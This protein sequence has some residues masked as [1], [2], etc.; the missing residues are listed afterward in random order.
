MAVTFASL[1]VNG[2]NTKDKQFK[3]KE[4][5]WKYKID[6]ILI[7][8]H[9]LKNHGSL[10]TDTFYDAYVNTC[11]LLKGSVSILIKKHAGINASNVQYH[12]SSR[13]IQMK[14]NVNGV[15]FNIL[16]IYAHFG[17]NLKKEREDLF[18]QEM[19]YY[20]QGNL[21]NVLIGGDFN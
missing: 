5:A 4:F 21:D 6:I 1:N 17:S 15:Y 20:L 16:N 7:Q 14:V 18:E 2:L 3:L 8:E 10:E 9:N 13:I 11:T 19:L 12:H